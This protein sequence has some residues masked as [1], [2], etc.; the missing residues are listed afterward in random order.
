MEMYVLEIV[1][2]KGEV[3][4]YS[5]SNKADGGMFA[6]CCGYVDGN[7]AYEN[8]VTSVVVYNN[9]KEEHYFSSAGVLSGL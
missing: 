9:E 4:T 2:L 5:K 1:T 8:L 3:R 7:V 6:G